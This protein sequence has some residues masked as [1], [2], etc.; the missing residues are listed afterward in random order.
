MS[1]NRLR[2]L[3]TATVITGLLLVLQGLWDTAW[4]NAFGLGLIILGCLLRPLEQAMQVIR[5]RLDPKAVSGLAERDLDVLEALIY[6]GRQALGLTVYESALS[7]GYELSRDEV[8]A[9]LAALVDAG[10]A[11]EGAEGK[12][13]IFHYWAANDQVRTILAEERE[14]RLRFPRPGSRSRVSGL[15]ERVASWP[16]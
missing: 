4:P 9:S 2:A 6:E 8:Y 5:C 10:L 15:A 16:S 12:P 13:K 7:L 11:Y 3:S 14:R 1:A